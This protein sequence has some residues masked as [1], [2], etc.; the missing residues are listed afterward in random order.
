MCFAQYLPH[1]L[2]LSSFQASS[3]L[4]LFATQVDPRNEV[5][6]IVHAVLNRV[7]SDHSTKNIYGNVNY[8]KTFLQGTVIHVFDERTPG[9]G[10]AIWKLTVDF[11][12][13]SKE[14]TLGVELKRAAVHWQH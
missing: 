13:H 9:G 8:A 2:L 10:N 12:M 4:S 14:P 5:G 7:L 6:T 3:V 1:P 11:E